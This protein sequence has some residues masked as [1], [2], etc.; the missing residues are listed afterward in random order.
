MAAGKTLTID[1]NRTVIVT[2]AGDDQGN[3]NCWTM[4]ADQAEKHLP[5]FAA[6]AKK[7]AAGDVSAIKDAASD[8]KNAAAQDAKNL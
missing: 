2:E 3:L 6:H 8:F 7:L 5:T 1:P 4:R